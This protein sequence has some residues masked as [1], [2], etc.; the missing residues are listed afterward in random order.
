MKI[1]VLAEKPS[2][3]RDFYRPLLEKISG[4]K[5]TDKNGYFES[6]SYYLAWFFGHIMATY[7]PVEYDAK[8]KKWDIND[9]PIMPQEIKY[10]YRDEKIKTHGEMLL[11]LCNQSDELVCATDPDREGEGIFRA[12]YD[13]HKLQ[14]P[15]KRLWAVS[16]TDEDLLNSWRGMKS[17]HAYDNL[18]AARY[19]RSSA[20][21]LVGMNASRAY[22]ICAYTNLPIGRVL[23]PT[24]ALIVA[25]DREVENYKELFTYS[26]K[27]KWQ[28]MDFIFFN[29]DG[30]KFEQEKF[31][32]K[33]NSQESKE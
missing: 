6:P 23:T 28:N 24:L 31:C 7:E 10:R 32:Q 17:S 3:A 19:M 5:F 20:D 29:E 22:S 25:R 12:F 13:Y 26:I 2:Q 33:E 21:W 11:K 1:C 18:S 16:L 8:Y 15:V 27:A 30:T 9:M 4:E 14:K